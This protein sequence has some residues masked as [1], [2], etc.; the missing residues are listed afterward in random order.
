MSFLF[1]LVADG[2]RWIAS[3]TG[4]TYNEINIIAYYIVLPFVYLALVD[5]I[6]RRHILKLGYLL[7]WAVLL[8]VIRDFRVFS[9]GLFQRS[10]EFLL[11]FWRFG[12]NYVAASVVVCVVLP[13]LVFLGLCYWAFP[14]LRS[15]WHSRKKVPSDSPPSGS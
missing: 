7:F 10:V 3:V 14:S 2:L 13:L 4:L 12:L 6:L 1:N 9:D 11:L 5:R 15:L 8:G